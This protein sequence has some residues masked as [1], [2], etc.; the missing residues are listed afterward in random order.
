M[1]WEN[2]SCPCCNCE[3]F[4]FSVCFVYILTYTVLQS[5][6][7][8]LNVYSQTIY[9]KSH[10]KLFITLIFSFLFFFFTS[11]IQQL[12]K[13][14][15]TTHRTSERWE[16][17]CSEAAQSHCS[18]KLCVAFCDFRLK[19]NEPQVN[20]SL[21]KMHQWNFKLWRPQVAVRGTRISHFCFSVSLWQMDAY[22]SHSSACYYNLN[23]HWCCNNIHY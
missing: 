4:I 9:S 5:M 22:A 3:M 18:N 6:F 12:S 14:H 17:Q 13:H 20:T 7:K 2:V 8:C 15:L 16:L 21:H 23:P 1:S 11:G 10:Y 19:L